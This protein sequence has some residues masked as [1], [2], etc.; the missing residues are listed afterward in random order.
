MRCQ[1]YFRMPRPRLAPHSPKS[2]IFKRAFICA[3]AENC[4]CRSSFT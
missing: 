1:H 3:R 4:I 2:G